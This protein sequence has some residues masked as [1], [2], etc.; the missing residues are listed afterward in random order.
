M[1]KLIASS[2]GALTL[3]SGLAFATA[4]PAG[5]VAVVPTICAS[6]PAQITTASAAQSVA[7]IALGTA[8]TAFTAAASAMNTSF[9][10][11]A[12]A[13]ANWLKA[14]DLGTG[15]ADAKLTMDNKL[16]ELASK[17]SAWSAAKAA[18]FVAQN[19]L[20]GATASLN[21]I[22]TFASALCS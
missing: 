14:V 2:L 10:E 17:I 7:G 15:V 1:R 3:A 6:L 21:L 9:G 5:A 20:D 22:G 8:N 19:T 4:S 16:A 12:V 18:V 13:V 11:Y